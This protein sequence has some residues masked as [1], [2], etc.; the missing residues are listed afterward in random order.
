MAEGKLILV[1]T[2]IGNLNDISKRAIETLSSVDLVACEDTRR[3][4]QL[5]KNLDIKKPLL[6]YYEE[7]ELKQIPRI[8]EQ[9]R[10]GETIALVTDSGTPTISDPGFKLV[11]EAISENIPVDII[12]GPSAVISALAISG[13]P[14]NR[15]LFLGFLPPKQGKRKSVFSQVR[16]VQQ[17]MNSTVI[18]Y[19]S[20]HKLTATLEDL[21]D[22]MGDL[23][24]VICRE[25][26][27][28][29]QEIRREKISESL[30]HFSKTKPK[31]E[32]TIV[33]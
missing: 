30:K 4:G 23:D 20:P 7:N 10:N 21:K 31:G 8:I 29:F 27:K 2:P 17:I 25:L 11:R 19:E 1:S 14:T 3:T 16:D 32:F 26:T 9:L 24:I 6:S 28:V 12:P 33:F 18:F 15:F 22:V 13:L 5:L